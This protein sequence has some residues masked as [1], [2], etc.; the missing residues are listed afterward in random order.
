MNL[1]FTR[2][3]LLAVPLALGMWLSPVLADPIG[4]LPTSPT[5][6]SSLPTGPFVGHGGSISSPLT[7]IQIEGQGVISPNPGDVWDKEIHWDYSPGPGGGVIN[8]G[9]VLCI[10]EFITL[11]HSPSTSTPFPITDWEENLI[12]DPRFTWHPTSSIKVNGVDA[13]PGQINGSQIR[14]D[15]GPVVPGILDSSSPPVTLEIQKYITYTGTSAITAGAPP[16]VFSFIVRE[17]PSVPEPSGLVPLALGMSCW[18]TRR[19]KR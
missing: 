15:Y 12:G 11:F 4:I 13:G 16:D 6:P 14:F 9:D 2:S 5:G 3:L 8:P 10:D 19:R 7:P 17:Q 18:I 1:H